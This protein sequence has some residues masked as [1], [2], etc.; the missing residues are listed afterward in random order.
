MKESKAVQL[1]WQI[2]T[3]KRQRR[4]EMHFP[5]PEVRIY[6]RK[7]RA[8]KQKP[9]SKETELEPKHKKPHNICHQWGREPKRVPSP[10]NKKAARCITSV[11]S[12]KKH[13]GSRNSESHTGRDCSCTHYQ[14][15]S[16]Q[17]NSAETTV[18]QMSLRDVYPEKLKRDA[19]G[20]ATEEIV[21]SPELQLDE[22][23]LR[24]SSSESSSGARCTS[25]IVS[26]A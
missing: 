22:G 15:I 14:Q 5:W 4:V 2:H 8:P 25:E 24:R 9:N 16:C 1:R 13:T 11:Q 26:T 10:Q 3:E 23:H 17:P 7:D 19:S 21:L 12:D 18:A 20:W 6:S